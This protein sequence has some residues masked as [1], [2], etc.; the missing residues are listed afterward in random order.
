MKGRSK[1][2]TFLNKKVDIF[3]ATSYIVKLKN[4]R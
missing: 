4:Y 3:V 1:K 2:I